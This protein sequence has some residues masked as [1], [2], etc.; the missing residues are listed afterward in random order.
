MSRPSKAEA[1]E[2]ARL[3]RAAGMIAGAQEAAG[4]V[5]IRLR[6]VRRRA[7]A[8]RELVVHGQGQLTAIADALDEAHALLGAVLEEKQ[9]E[10][11]EQHF[12]SA[13]VG[14]E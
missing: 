6:Q 13:E 1:L 3:E 5:A 12:G 8:L 11:H 9:R 10:R 4:I 7:P 2:L 14:D